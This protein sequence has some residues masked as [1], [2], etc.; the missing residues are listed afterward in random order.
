MRADILNAFLAAAGNSMSKE[1][2]SAIKRTGLHMD[3]SE[4]VTDEVTVY[5]SMVGAVRGM[6]L[7]GMSLTT[8]RAMAATMVGEPQDEL[9]EMGL[10]ALAEMG[11]LIA[12]GA[13]V[14]LEKI[15][16]HADIT[17][18]TIMIGSKSRIS[19]LG[20]HRFVV[21]LATK[22]GAVNLHVAVDV[23]T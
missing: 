4:H 22:H 23:Q 7:V 14:E 3:P 18:P 21:P 6:V 10:S 11:N 9:N 2:Q 15:G 13:C 5:L 1:V 16:L 19:T 20:V 17:P 8:A 12:G